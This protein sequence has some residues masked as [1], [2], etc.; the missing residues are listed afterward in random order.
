MASWFSWNEPHR[1]IPHREPADVVADTLMVELSWQLKEAERQQRERESEYR[2][3]KTG[4]DYSWLASVPRSSYNIS[5]GERLG[6]EDLCSKVPPSCC[7]LVILKFR[8]TIRASEPEVHEVSG[9]FRS[10]LLEAVEQLKEEQE[11]QR[12]ARQW[13]NKR[14]KSMSLVNFRSRIKINP[15]GSAAGLISGEGGRLSDLKTVS[16]DVERGSEREERVWS[17]PDFRYKGTSSSKLV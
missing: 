9:L 1:R 8:D 5:T 7:G 16:E 4:V 2:R 17:M 11:S 15:F 13:S 6:L 3:L 12:L 10:V 14:A